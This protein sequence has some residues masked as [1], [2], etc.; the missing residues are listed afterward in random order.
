MF[1]SLRLNSMEEKPAQ[2]A[3]RLATFQTMA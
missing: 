3:A 1:Y 2:Q